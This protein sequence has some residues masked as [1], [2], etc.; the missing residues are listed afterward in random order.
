VPF[1]LPSQDLGLLA[2]ERDIWA[3]KAKYVLGDQLA[4]Q[5]QYTVAHPGRQWPLWSLFFFF[6]S[7]NLYPQ[8]SCTYI[9]IPFSTSPWCSNCSPSKFMSSLAVL[10][11]SIHMVLLSLPSSSNL[12]LYI[13]ELNFIMRVNFLFFCLIVNNQRSGYKLSFLTVLVHCRL[14]FMIGSIQIVSL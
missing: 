5:V 7:A 9:K 1:L 6:M 2:L 3:L 8:Y 10:I 14:T 12:F 11:R 13:I 4:W